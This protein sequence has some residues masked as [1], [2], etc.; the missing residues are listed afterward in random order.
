MTSPVDEPGPDGPAAHGLQRGISQQHASPIDYRSAVGAEIDRL[1]A[2]ALFYR[3]QTG[4][5]QFVECATD[6][7]C[8]MRETFCQS[9]W[10][11]IRSIKP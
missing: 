7:H 6:R 8:R 10:V 2:A 3:S 4:S 11:S 1:A 9:G 5:S